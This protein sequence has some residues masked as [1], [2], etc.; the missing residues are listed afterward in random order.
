MCKRNIRSKW[1]YKSLAKTANKVQFTLTGYINRI[2]KFNYIGYVVD[3]TEKAR[4]AQQIRY[5]KKKSA[6]GKIR[7]LYNKKYLSVNIRHY[8]TVVKP[9]IFNGSERLAMVSKRGLQNILQKER[10]NMSVILGP[11]R[12]GEGY[13]LRTRDTT[14]TLSKIAADTREIML[15]LDK[16]INRLSSDRIT[17]SFL[18]KITFRS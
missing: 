12:T 2:Q 3:P 16:H 7:N 17:K 15:K 11:R 6:L 1:Q 10:Q 8:N 18:P 9:D 4:E 14:E 5:Q 13:R